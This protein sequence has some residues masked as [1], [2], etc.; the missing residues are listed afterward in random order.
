MVQWAWGCVGVPIRHTG[1]IWCPNN[2]HLGEYLQET[3]K[4]RKEGTNVTGQDRFWVF[5]SLFSFFPH[6]INNNNNNNKSYCVC[7]SSPGR[8]TIVIDCD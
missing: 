2:P 6:S 8:Q 1:V 7:K 4:G 5:C 3:L